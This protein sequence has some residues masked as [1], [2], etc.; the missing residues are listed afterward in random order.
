MLILI[1]ETSESQ[2]AFSLNAC[3]QLWLNV[4][5]KKQ[6]RFICEVDF[7]F[8]SQLCLSLVEVTINY[9]NS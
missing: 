8:V 3:N 7:W 4:V 9:F 6:I 5:I 2:K 1:S